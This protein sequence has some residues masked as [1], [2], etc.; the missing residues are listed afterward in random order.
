GDVLIVHENKGLTD[1]FKALPRR[2]AGDG[3]HALCVDLLSEEGGTASFS[4]PAKATAALTAAPRDRLVGDLSAGLDELARR[5][6]GLRMGVMGFCF[7]GGMTWSLLNAGES[8][9]AAAIPFYGPLP[10]PVDFSRAKAAVLAIYGEQDT[11]V[12]PS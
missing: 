6:P 8:R 3:Y 11:F 5:G 9:L 12:N 2:L 10:E 7:G 1:H 4:D